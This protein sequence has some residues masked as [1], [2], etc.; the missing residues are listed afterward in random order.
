[1]STISANGRKTLASQLD[2]L[3]GILDALSSGLNETV[4]DVVEQAVERVVAAA[5]Q[6]AVAQVLA[7]PAIRARLEILE[8]K[9]S[10]RSGETLAGK[11]LAKVRGA[12][13]VLGGWVQLAWHAVRGLA[14]RARERA[15]C[16]VTTAGGSIRNG[17]R[18]ACTRAWTVA[19]LLWLGAVLL[20]QVGLRFRR[21]LLVA[22][23]A[24]VAVGAACYLAGPAVAAVVSGVNSLLLALVAQVLQSLWRLSLATTEARAA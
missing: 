24:G 12:C 20:A 16:A 9:E 18:S 21:P 8:K 5:V 23:A 6:Q 14:R 4:A 11:I 7:H 19:Q 2:R 13:G 17:I 15:S 1:M 10:E 3:D 22:L